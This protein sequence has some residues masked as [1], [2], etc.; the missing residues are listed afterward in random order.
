MS[1]VVLIVDDEFSNFLVIREY[2]SAIGVVAILAKDGI[3]AVECVQGNADIK[4]VFMDL[5]MPQMDGF[6]ATRLIGAI[7]PGLP[8]I[9]Q[10][11]YYYNNIQEEIVCNGFDGYLLKP[12]TEEQLL[13]VVKKYIPVV[14]ET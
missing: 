5:R 9:A 4:L 7:R 1:D 13:D 10:T 3:E 2:L 14:S 6:Y 11:A 8:V 12:F